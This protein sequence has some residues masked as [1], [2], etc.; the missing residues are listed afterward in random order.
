MGI[1]D[2]RQRYA[3]ADPLGNDR[4]PCSPFDSPRKDHDEHQ[5]ERYIQD[6]REENEQ[7]RPEGFSYAPEYGDQA[8]ERYEEESSPDIDLKVR[9]GLRNDIFRRVGQPEDRFG[10][11]NASDRKQQ[12]CQQ[13][14]NKKGRKGPLHPVELFGSEKLRYDDRC[15]A[16]YP[17]HQG[18]NEIVNEEGGGDG[19]Q[20][21]FPE[22]TADD[23]TVRHIV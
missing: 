1:V 13:H 16:A 12:P 6:C 14:K 21:L 9:N 20:C 19:C 5:I 15:A 2:I 8:I 22:K 11:D 4:S 3:H 10:E 17:D 23:N 18:N 7:H